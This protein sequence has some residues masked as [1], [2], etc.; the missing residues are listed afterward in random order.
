MHV[1][2]DLFTI[3]RNGLR[4]GLKDVVI[5]HSNYKE[6]IVKILIQEGYVMSYKVND[7]KNNKKE[8]KITL[9]YKDNQSVIEEIK[10]ISKPGNRQYINKSSIPKIL[11][12]F[13]VTILSTSRGVLTGKQARKLNVGGELLG[14]IY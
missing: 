10:V 8:L 11:N 14:V 9:K 2:S 13:G 6:S 1:V 7:L 12:G 3:I 5:R 4:V